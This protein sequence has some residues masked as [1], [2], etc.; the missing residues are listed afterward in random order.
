[1]RENLRS[2]ELVMDNRALCTSLFNLVVSDNITDVV[3]NAGALSGTQN[4]LAKLLIDFA[5]P[6][7]RKL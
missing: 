5:K 6:L 1:M 4:R 3:R 7:S 2:R